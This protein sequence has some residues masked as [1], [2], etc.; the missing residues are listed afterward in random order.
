MR[1]RS[2][3]A[4]WLELAVAP[5]WRRGAAEIRVHP[6]RRCTEACRALTMNGRW[7][8]NSDGRL[9]VFED[10][11]AVARFLTLVHVTEY[12]SDPLRALPDDV[13][14]DFYCLSVCSRGLCQCRK[15]PTEARPAGFVL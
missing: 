2:S 13:D 8:C 3:V 15:R 14:S 6:V 1:I 12:E 4:T 7:L 9:T 10:D 11:D 5:E